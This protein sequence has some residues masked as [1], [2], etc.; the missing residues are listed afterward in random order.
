MVLPL[1]QGRERHGG[2]AWYLNS[3]TWRKT[4]LKS[5]LD[6]ASYDTVKQVGFVVVYDEGET[7]R[8]TGQAEPSFD[9]WHGFTSRF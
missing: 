1:R 2:P 6:A 4:V 9:F 8:L 3:G 7:H 5:G